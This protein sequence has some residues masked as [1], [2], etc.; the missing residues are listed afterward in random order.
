MAFP[1]AVGHTVV[2]KQNAG[3]FAIASHH[4]AVRRGRA[5]ARISRSRRAFGSA[6]G[7]G[8]GLRPAKPRQ[9]RIAAVARI[10]EELVER[11]EDGGRFDAGLVDV[12]AKHGATMCDEVFRAICRDA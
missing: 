3:D 8:P 1:S 9:S 4:Q 2:A 7:L 10:L 5:D 11:Q 6:A 12:D